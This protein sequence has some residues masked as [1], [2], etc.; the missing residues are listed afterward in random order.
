MEREALSLLF[1]AGG[2]SYVN[3]GIE[4]GFNGKSKSEIT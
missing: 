2:F 1:V 4:R 3:M